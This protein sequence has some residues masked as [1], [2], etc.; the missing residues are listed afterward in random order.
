MATL[1][2]KTNGGAVPSKM[3]HALTRQTFSFKRTTRGK[4]GVSLADVTVH[5]LPTIP[6]FTTIIPDL[7]KTRDR[8]GEVDADHTGPSSDLREVGPILVSYTLDRSKKLQGITDITVGGIKRQIVNHNIS[9]VWGRRRGRD[10][11]HLNPTNVQLTPKLHDLGNKLRV[12]SDPCDLISTLLDGQDL[13]VFCGKMVNNGFR[14]ITISETLIKIVNLE[15]RAPSQVI[16]IYQHDGE[17]KL[18]PDGQGTRPDGR[19][20]LTS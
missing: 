3:P 8:A 17:K 4:M 1:T 11:T 12:K 9:P 10:D 15:V 2:F 14:N 19:P 20:G 18:S 13:H 16:L 5:R 7:H 6:H